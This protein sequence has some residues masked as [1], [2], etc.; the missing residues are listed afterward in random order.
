VVFFYSTPA[1]VRT[2]ARDLPF[3]VVA[4][5]D[6]Q[7]YEGRRMAIGPRSRR[8]V[9][10]LVQSSLVRWRREGGFRREIRWGLGGMSTR[11]N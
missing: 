10:Y 2:Y 5:P 8:A 4:D 6:K 7:L 1:E 11:Q 9:Y 3:D